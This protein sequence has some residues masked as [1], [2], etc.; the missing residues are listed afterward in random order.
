MP[1]GAR[2]QLSCDLRLC[3]ASRLRLGPVSSKR[4][5]KNMVFTDFTCF[6]TGL[7]VAILFGEST[8]RVPICNCIAGWLTLPLLFIFIIFKSWI[9]YA[10]NLCIQHEETTQAQICKRRAYAKQALCHTCHVRPANTALVPL[11]T[12]S[13]MIFRLSSR[14]RLTSSLAW[15]P[16]YLELD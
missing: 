4:A 3:L 5:W 9:I 16:R 1:P 13:G 15:P 8:S 11:H 7:L 12:P 6:C 14:T 2:Q 10:I